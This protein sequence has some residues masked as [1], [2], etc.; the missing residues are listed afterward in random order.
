M[1]WWL[2]HCG[3]CEAFC[4]CNW[5]KTTSGFLLFFSLKKG[6]TDLTSFNPTLEPRYSIV[7]SPKSQIKTVTTKGIAWY[8]TNNTV[9]LILLRFGKISFSPAS[10]LIATED[11]MLQYIELVNS[12][13]TL[14]SQMQ[15]EVPLQVLK[16]LSVTI[17]DDLS[18]VVTERPIIK[19]EPHLPSSLRRTRSDASSD[20][21][22]SLLAVINT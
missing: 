5:P 4:Y 3:F 19:G 1:R 13:K 12:G 14:K 20:T 11:G 10:Y 18:P 7:L 21:G 2:W 8:A 16:F 6:K 22:S 15:E 9:G 17:G